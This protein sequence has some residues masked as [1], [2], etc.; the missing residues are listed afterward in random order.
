MMSEA[1]YDE[2]IVGSDGSPTANRAL[3]AAISLALRTHSRLTVATA[4]YRDM[5][6]SPVASERVKMPGGEPASHE[7]IWAEQTSQEGAVRARNAG[8][9]DVRT[10]TPS[11]NPAEALIEL[12]EKRRG[13]LVVVGSH[14]LSDRTERVLLGNIPNKLVHH[15]VRDLLIIRT[16]EDESHNWR[17]MALA[18][19]GS[20]T[21]AVAVE[22]GFVLARRMGAE[23]TIVTV[24]KDEAHGLEVLRGAATDLPGGADLPRRVVV[25]KH[26]DK[27]LIQA[28]ADYDVL[29]IGNKGTSGPSRFLGSVAN[30]VVYAIPTDILLVNTTR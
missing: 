19:D 29:V 4:W 14:G 8:V 6:D 15:S 13:S 11:G 25:D 21:A 12:S 24:A 9:A 1:L 16:E 27:A 28:G 23:P 26:A 5:P 7:A 17:T 30:H 3:N 20:R 10:A 2:I 18:T 22:H